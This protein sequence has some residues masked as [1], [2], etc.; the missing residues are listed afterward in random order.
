MNTQ[1][2]RPAGRPAG[3]LLPVTTVKTARGDIYADSGAAAKK[4]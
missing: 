3:F 1:L 2:F 4:D